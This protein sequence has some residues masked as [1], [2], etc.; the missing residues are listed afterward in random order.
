M[1][2]ICGIFEKNKDNQQLVEKMHQIIAHRGP[3]A[4]GVFQSRD[5]CLGTPAAEYHRFVYR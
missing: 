2:G 5:V 1:C 3:D 4:F